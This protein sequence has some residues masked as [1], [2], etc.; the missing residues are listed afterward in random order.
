MK[1]L[2]LKVFLLLSSITLR[3]EAMNQAVPMN[4]A[5]NI[6]NIFVAPEQVLERQDQIIRSIPPVYQRPVEIALIQTTFYTSEEIA[7]KLTIVGEL[8]RAQNPP[9]HW[10]VRV[11]VRLQ[12]LLDNDNQVNTDPALLFYCISQ[13]NALVARITNLQYENPGRIADEVMM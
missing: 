13:R 12:E 8:R 5:L 11:A 2:L 3:T 7:Q 9:L 6:Q 4:I 10:M 1:N